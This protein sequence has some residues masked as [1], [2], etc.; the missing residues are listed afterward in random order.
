MTE[1]SKWPH[2]G[3]IL[4]GGKSSR[5][6]SPK[7]AL[8]LPNGLTLIE[9][10]AKAMREVCERIVVVSSFEAL[11]GEIHIP[12]I[13]SEQGPLGGIEALLESGQDTQY[14]ICPCDLPFVNGEILRA[15]TKSSSALATVLSIEGEE[16]LVPLP[17]RISV[18]ALYKV[19]EL[20][21]SDCR[22]VN[23]L[24]NVI[25]VDEIAAPKKW[26]HLLMN[27]NTQEDFE[28][29]KLGFRSQDAGVR[30]EKKREDPHP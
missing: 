13:R 17:A 20:L 12:D 24:M 19:R 4:A 6:G 11:E 29:V 23:K 10:V 27:V 15:L 28:K 22:A 7:H 14:L 25:S 1:Q 5:F 30:E 8:K 9:T 21:D 2:T 18:D 3:A 16:S 26:S